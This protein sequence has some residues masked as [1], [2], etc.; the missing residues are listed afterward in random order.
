MGQPECPLCILARSCRSRNQL[1]LVLESSCAVQSKETKTR[2]RELR[3]EAGSQRDGE[4]LRGYWGKP[5]AT[6]L[7]QQAGEEVQRR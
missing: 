3:W 6:Q 4:V 5:D 7:L 1:D 2:P